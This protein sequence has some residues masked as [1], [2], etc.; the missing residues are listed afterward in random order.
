MT[1]QILTYCILGVIAL[2]AGW[3]LSQEIRIRLLE[4]KLSESEFQNEKNKIVS[5]VAHMSRGQL[6][7]ELSTDLGRNQSLTPKS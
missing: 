1:N 2:I 4:A 6:D 7:S 3:I 5:T